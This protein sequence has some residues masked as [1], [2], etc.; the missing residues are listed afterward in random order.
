VPPAG[1]VIG[2]N[3][4]RGLS[5]V[6][7]NWFPSIGI[8]SLD[9]IETYVADGFGVGF[10]VSIPKTKLSPKVRSLALK[11]F[12]PAVPGGLWRRKPS[13]PLRTLLDELQASA[14]RLRL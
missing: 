7:I 1:E 13:P 9:T 10:S 6:G 4:Q 3:F 14:C 11:D 8:N 5:R 12:A 2:R